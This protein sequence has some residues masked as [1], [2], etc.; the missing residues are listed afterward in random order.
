MNSDNGCHHGHQNS[1]CRRKKK[2]PFVK[3]KGRPNN[4]HDGRHNNNR[5]DDTIRKEKFL[6]ANPDLRE[7]VF[8]AK[9]NWSEH[10]V[11]FTTVDNIIK[12]QVGTECDQFVLKSLEKEV[13]SGPKE[14][15]AVTKE[16]G[17]RLIGYSAVYII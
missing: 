1:C 14:P 2:K 17:T 5:R 9:R 12:A 8:G 10:V 11:N 16:D 6:G 13:E 4:Q 7:H 15:T 3:H